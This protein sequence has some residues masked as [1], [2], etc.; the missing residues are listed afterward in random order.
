MF[1]KIKMS[2]LKSI[3]HRKQVGSI[4]LFLT[5]L[6]LA[7]VLI[8]AFGISSI[9]LKQIKMSGQAGQS[10]KAYQAADSGI[11]WALYQISQGNSIADD[12]LC[13]NCTL[14]ID[15]P[16]VNGGSYCLK[17]IQG[18]TENPEIIKAIGRVG[19]ARRAA[20]VTLVT[21]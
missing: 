3:F 6:I 13:S 20:E 5:I 11:E 14:G 9:I 19:Q 15:C 10:V 16:E 2:L 17:I 4:S 18:T 8:I 1:K 7:G 21:E 12:H